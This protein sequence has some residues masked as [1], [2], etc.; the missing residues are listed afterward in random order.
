LVLGF[1]RHLRVLVLDPRALVVR[2]LAL[3]AS[4]PIRKRVET[5]R[6]GNFC[7]NQA[8][9]WAIADAG[10]I[11]GP[12]LLRVGHLWRDKW[13]VLSG[14]LATLSTL[15]ADGGHWRGRGHLPVLVR[16]HLLQR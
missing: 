15:D 14:P 2:L 16:H 4:N 12:G 10:W 1:D 9:V 8:F 6:T 11:R 13:T 7:S 5:T 3:R